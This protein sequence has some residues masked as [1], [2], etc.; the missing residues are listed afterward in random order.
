[1]RR[2][3]ARLNLEIQGEEYRT[4]LQ[5]LKEKA[6]FLR[7][8]DT[9][10]DVVAFMRD[11]EAN[12]QLTDE[13]VRPVFK[14]HEESGDR[15]WRTILLVIFWPGLESIH[16]RKRGWDPD[17][18]ERW[19]NLVWTFLQV[20]CRIDVRRRPDRLVQ[21]VINDTI[22]YLHDEYREI[23]RIK[24]HEILHENSEKETSNR[25]SE[26]SPQE[27]MR[28]DWVRKLQAYVQEG[29]INEADF[30]LIV[31]TRIYGKPL[32]D[33]ARECGLNYQAISKRRRRA[34][35]TIRNYE[36]NFHEHVQKNKKY[37][38]LYSVGNLN[39]KG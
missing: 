13:V 23:W 29:R 27:N 19:Q 35:A 26:C 21:K 11:S 5:K 20:V 36:K 22:H 38:P 1:M 30:I 34:E 6:E 37:P 18:E 10:A 12:D 9:W 15:R 16:W 28:L 39:R 3:Y 24:N 14:M 4:L 33:Y 32:T 8:F 7:R 31:G 2:E 25:K 17:I